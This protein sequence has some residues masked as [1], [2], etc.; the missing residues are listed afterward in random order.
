[1]SALLDRFNALPPEEAEATLLA[2]CGSDR[3]ARTLV[4][5]RPFADFDHLCHRATN[6]WFLLDE[7][8]WLQA[9]AQHPR[10]G[11]SK[12]A[13][14]DFLAHSSHEQQTALQ[15]LAPV[16]EALV[17]GNQA[18]EARFGFLYVV[19]ANG[20]TSPE[21]LALLEA[22]LGRDRITELHEAARQQHRIT[23]LRLRAWLGVQSG[24]PLGTQP[25][26]SV[27]A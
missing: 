19:Y 15:T 13:A 12:P 26:G 14:T 7:H 4:A 18:Y 3:W 23:E 27:G 5:Q 1:M 21:L 24:V 8:D 16:A 9:F 10:I 17:R 11:E 25:N 22:R 6:L 2:L 20:Q